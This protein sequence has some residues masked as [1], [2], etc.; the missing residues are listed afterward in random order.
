MPEAHEMDTKPEMVQIHFRITTAEA[1]RMDIKRAE[2][3]K[4]Q[5]V[6]LSRTAYAARL[7]IQGLYA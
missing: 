4:A 3:R 1:A 5:N 6:L 2:Y 7:V